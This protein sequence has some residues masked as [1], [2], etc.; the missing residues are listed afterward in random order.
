MSY[1]AAS[2]QEDD[3][4]IES[5]LAALKIG[6]RASAT[7]AR[8]KARLTT[9]HFVDWLKMIFIVLYRAWTMDIEMIPLFTTWVGPGAVE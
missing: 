4:A 6:G 7:P 8:G 1:L 9:S 5:N 3:A 2:R